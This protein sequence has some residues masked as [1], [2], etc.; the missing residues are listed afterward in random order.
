[1]RVEH[2]IRALAASENAGQTAAE[3]WL[4]NETQL[5]TLGASSDGRIAAILGQCAHESG[6]YLQRFENLN[7]SAAA[8]NRVFG[9]HFP[10][11]AIAENYARQPE[12]IAN[13]AYADRMGNGPEASGDGWRYRGRGYL[14]LTGKSNYRVFGDAIG[15][16]LVAE[17]ERAAEPGIAWLIAVRY[18]AS[19]SRS[20]RNL[21]EWADQDDDRMVTLG[22]NGGT[23]GLV[24]RERLT[25]RAQAVLS[26]EVPV[27]EW[28]RL[29]LAAGFDP[30]PIDGLKGKKTDA[31]RAAAAAA[32]KLDGPALVERL[33]Q[34]A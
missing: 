9:R 8:L 11:M 4:A 31:A 15:V 29:L 12:R 22:I 16:D 14:Q 6:G 10:T 26:G 18:M 20:G 30:G 7:Y 23:H 21:L 3:A 13:R 25:A 2:A 5:E 33:R 32:F 34:V 28:Q 27:V 24:E 19:R 17:P 1:M